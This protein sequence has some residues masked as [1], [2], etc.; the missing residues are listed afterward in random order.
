MIYVLEDDQSIRELLVYALSSS[1]M[2]TKGFEKPSELK[3]H[4]AEVMPDLLIL[5]IMLPE[6]DGLSILR[7]MRE[8]DQTSRLPIIMLTAKGTEYDKIVG[9]DTGA[10]DYITKPFSVMELVSRVKAL[11]RRSSSHEE[12][13]DEYKIGEIV[14]NVEKHTVFIGKE[15]IFLTLKEYE[16]LECLMKKPDTVFSRDALLSEIWGYDFCGESRTVDVHIRTLR[17][18]MGEAE[19][20]IETVRGVGYKIKGDADER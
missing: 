19:K 4:V 15:Q 20:Y 12:Q 17:Q 7:K 14:L 2:E 6:E 18:K 16:L 1:V 3:N 5:D 8:N 11:L 10:D 13:K 9:L